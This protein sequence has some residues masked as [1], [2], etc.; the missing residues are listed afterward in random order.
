MYHLGN[1]VSSTVEPRRGPQSDRVRQGPQ[2]K[3]Q[4]HSVIMT[5]LKTKSHSVTWLT[6]Q[7]PLRHHGRVK[8]PKGT[9][10]RCQDH[11]LQSSHL[12]FVR[13]LPGYWVEHHV[14]GWVPPLHLAR[15]VTWRVDFEKMQA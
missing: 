10:V 2:D 9:L 3:N 15:S 1:Q 12:V 7:K 8:S 5:G 11:S 4:S 6:N 14:Q 13:T